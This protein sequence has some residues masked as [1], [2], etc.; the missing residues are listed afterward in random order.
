MGITDPLPMA[1]MGL[2][3]TGRD[4]P[5]NGTE[6]ARK[7]RFPARRVFPSG[8][9]A[10]SARQGSVG[11]ADRLGPDTR[12]ATGSGFAGPALRLTPCG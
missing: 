11:F 6:T 2:S 10:R 7:R 12:C 4:V 3:H 8:E 1:D 5:M 9:P